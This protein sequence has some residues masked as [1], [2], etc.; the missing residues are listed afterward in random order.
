MI[1]W[2][3][4]GFDIAVLDTFAFLSYLLAFWVDLLLGLTLCRLPY[5]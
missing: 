5:G 1:K 2:L 4:G 3:D